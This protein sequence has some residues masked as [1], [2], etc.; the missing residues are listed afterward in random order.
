MSQQD[1]LNL[2]SEVS[3]R[4][5]DEGS[6]NMFIKAFEG[7][8]HKVTGVEILTLANCHSNIKLLRDRMYQKLQEEGVKNARIVRTTP[9]TKDPIRRRKTKGP[10]RKS[11]GRKRSSKSTA[12]GVSKGKGK[13]GKKHSGLSETK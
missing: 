1:Y 6:L 11:R 3:I 8:E 9:E 2:E 13:L 5:L 10:S 4:G 12:S 7:A